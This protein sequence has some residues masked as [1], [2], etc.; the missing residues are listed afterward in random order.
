[1]GS[2]VFFFVFVF[3]LFGVKMFARFYSPYHPTHPKAK[4]VEITLEQ[5]KFPKFSQFLSLSKKFQI[6]LLYISYLPH[7]WSLF[8]DLRASDPFWTHAWDQGGSVVL[9]FSKKELVGKGSW[10][11]V[12]VLKE[13][14]NTDENTNPPIKMGSSEKASPPMDGNHSNPSQVVTLLWM[15]P[16]SVQTMG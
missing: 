15:N 11:I 7:Q 2:T 4:L 12:V 5:Q 8:E 9:S 6:F 1:M 13:W 3:H 10:S 14:H 16:N